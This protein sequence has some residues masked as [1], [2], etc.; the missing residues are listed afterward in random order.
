VPVFLTVAPQAQGSAELARAILEH[1]A[2]LRATGLWQ[3]RECYRL[4]AELNAV[5]Q[6]S[7]VQRWRARVPDETYDR[8]VDRLVERTLS[9]SQAVR[10]LLEPLAE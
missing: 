8:V 7:L 9:P 1:A 5:L 10:M 4:R 6:D 2:Y 3:E